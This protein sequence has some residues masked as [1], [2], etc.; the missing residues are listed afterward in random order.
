MR[1]A[2]LVF[3]GKEKHNL[4]DNLQLMAIENLYKFMGIDDNDIVRIPYN[5]LSTWQEKEV[6]KVILPINFPFLEYKEEGLSGLFSKNIIPVFLGL[7]LLNNN[8]SKKDLAFLKEHEPVG[9]RD[10]Y[11]YNNLNK[12]GIEV[13]LNGCMTLTMFDKRSKEHHDNTRN[14]LIIDICN[15]LRNYIP[16]LI[17][18]NSI[19]LSQIVTLKDNMFI[20]DFVSRRYQMYYDRAKLVITSRL[21]CAVA[22]IAMGIPVILAVKKVS[23]RFGWLEKLLPIYS[24]EEFDSIDWNPAPINCEKI[25]SLMLRN[26]INRISEKSFNFKNTNEISNFWLTRKKSNYHIDGYEEAIECISKFGSLK[27][28]DYAFWGMTVLTEMI[29]QYIKETFPTA[30]LKYVFDKYR[31][32]KFDGLTTSSIRSFE[33]EKLQNLFIFVTA[34]AA[35][36]EAKEFFEKINIKIKYCLC[37]QNF[38][39]DQ[40]VIS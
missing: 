19:E 24:T 22:C 28:V 25:K 15:E 16:E 33:P 18:E 2:N 4:G 30:K 35:T 39:H 9:C 21:H 14:V 29:N 13:W 40:K 6:E 38:V 32:I 10:E 31:K 7:T 20:Q 23:F 36:Q 34:S 26:A 27:G 17:K 8:L 12:A 5:E 11:T 37:Y 3:V 1:Y